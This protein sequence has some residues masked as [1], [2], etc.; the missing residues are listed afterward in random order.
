LIGH[1]C[2]NTKTN[3]EKLADT[4]LDNCL[5][6]M[7]FPDEKLVAKVVAAMNAIMERI[8]K[9]NQM[10]LVQMIRR[11]IEIHGVQN[12]NSMHSLQK[13]EGSSIEHLYK[14]KV[15]VLM[16]FKNPVGVQSIVNYV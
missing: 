3:F 13:E 5:K 6:Y 8:P 7:N 9:E 2:A 4:Y 10:L 12:V 14:K 15:P 1:Y 16:I 11:Q